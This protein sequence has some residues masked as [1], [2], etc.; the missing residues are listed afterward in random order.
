MIIRVGWLVC[1]FCS[2]K[3]EMYINHKQKNGSPKFLGEPLVL[4]PKTFWFILW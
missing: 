2:L 1:L 4:L 3:K